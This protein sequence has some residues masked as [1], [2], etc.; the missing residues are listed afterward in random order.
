MRVERLLPRGRGD[1]FRQLAIWLGFGVAYEVVRGLADRGSGEALRNARRVIRIED[2]LGGL[3]ELDVQHWVMGAGRVLVHAVDWTYWLSQ[4]VVVGGALLW[5]YLRRNAAYARL[6]NTLIAVNT[7]GLVGYVALPTAPPRL[8]PGLGVAD[9]LASSE[10][11]NEGSGLVHLLANP[12]AAMPS[13][14]AA[15]ALIV[16]LVLAAVV[17]AWPLRALC[18]LWPVWVWFSLL[19]TGNHFWLDVAAGAALGALGIALMPRS[20]ADT[21]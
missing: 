11:L 1:F 8:V 10:P 17:R 6:R 2:R 14:H 20:V 9:T 12:Y 7:L 21:S 5:I 13:L 3:H 16:G 4:F 19:A 15:D 18:L